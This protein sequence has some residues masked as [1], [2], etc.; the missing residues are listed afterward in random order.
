MSTDT[1]FEKSSFVEGFGGGFVVCGVLLLGMFYTVYI[2]FNRKKED[3]DIYQVLGGR[4]PVVERNLLNFA[5]S[6]L[7][8]ASSSARQ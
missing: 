8:F 3:V 4:K 2:F 7:Y 6:R 1:F 5:L